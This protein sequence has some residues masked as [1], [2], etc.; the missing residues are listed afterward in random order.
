[1]QAFGLYGYSVSV[2]VISIMLGVAGI[3]LGFG[4]ALDNKKLKEFGKNEI[5]QSVFNG[6][7]VGSLMALFSANGI[8]SM[9][10][11]GISMQ[12]NTSL[13]CPLLL[14]PNK[15]MCVAYNYLVSPTPYTFMGST[16]MSILE[17]SSILLGVLYGVYALLGLASIFL[18]PLL[19]QIKYAS[20]LVATIAI[21]ASLQASFIL[22]AAAT[23]IAVILPLGMVLRTFY[24]TRK[25]G[26]FLIAFA[27]GIYVVLP[28]SYVF[29]AYVANG[30]ISQLPAELSQLS[31]I[32]TYGTYAN[33]LSSNTIPGKIY[34]LIESGMDVLVG[35]IE[36]VFGIL[37]YLVLYA[38]VLPLF[39]LVLTAISIK[40][41]ASVMGSDA[42]VLDRFRLI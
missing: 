7:L 37:A 6:L 17:L 12:A 36:K 32:S 24:L 1:M 22:F 16:N 25:L 20:Q 4:F 35:F 40:E 28:L 42:G 23:A 29:N 21:S 33:A 31:Q 15:A 30:Y 11:N 3:A 38:F 41:L 26:S 18:A 5:M 8:V 2:L 10:L 34:S 9:M 39:S 27:I 13:S 19:S 14:Q